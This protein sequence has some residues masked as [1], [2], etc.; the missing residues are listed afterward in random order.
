MDDLVCEALDALLPCRVRRGELRREGRT[1]RWVEAGSGT[2]AVVLEAALGEPGSLA[3]AGIMA[4]VAGQT[5]AVAYDRAGIGA[6]DPVSPL[7]LHSQV[8]DLAAV[9]AAVGGNRPCVLA[10]HSWGGLLALLAAAQHPSLI[11]GLVLIDPADEIYWSQLPAEIHRES[12]ATGDMIIAKHAA[13]ELGPMVRE[14]FGPYVDRLTEDRRHRDRL[15]DAYE[16]CYRNAWQARMVQDETRLFNDSIQLI[17]RIRSSA[18]LPDV[19]VVVL[20]A[21][22]GAAEE[23]RARWTAAHAKLAQAAPAGTHIV[24]ADTHHAINQERPEAITAAISQV[25]AAVRL[26]RHRQAALS[27]T[28][29]RGPR[30]C[31]TAPARRM[32]TTSAAT[33]RGHDRPASLGRRLPPAPVTFPGRFVVGAGTPAPARP[34]TRE[35]GQSWLFTPAGPRGRLMRFNRC[36]WSRSSCTCDSACEIL[37]AGAAGP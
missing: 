10:G 17:N 12:T 36:G 31:Q 7:T 24:L 19:P 21:T 1:L 35:P 15:L 11:A 16:S 30:A 27:Q 37:T 3:Y 34:S 26:V 23:H 2:P 5:R 6:S 9:A 25:M 14:V 4:A 18:P 8:G 22:T 29:G 33:K 28:G 32:R 20:S 13:G